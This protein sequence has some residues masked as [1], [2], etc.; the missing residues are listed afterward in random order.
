[1]TSRYFLLVVCFLFSASARSWDVDA[2]KLRSDPFARPALLAAP[3]IGNSKT[4]KESGSNWNPV[5]LST[6]RSS[7]SA[8]VNVAGRLLTVGENIDGYTLIEVRERSAVFEKSG[9]RY[10]LEMDTRA[11]DEDD[12]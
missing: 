6:L 2:P 7:K 11:G 12:T 5:L 9:T 4:V 3:A 10:T 8:M 1:M